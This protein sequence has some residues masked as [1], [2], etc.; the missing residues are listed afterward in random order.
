MTS[1]GRGARAARRGVWSIALLASV[2]E[3]TVLPMKL[4]IELP[5]AQAEKL[6]AEAERLGLSAEELARAALNDLLSAPDPEFQAVARRVVSKNQDLYKRLPDAY[7]T[8]GEVVALHRAILET[9]GGASGIRDLGAWSRRSL[10]PE[11]VS[12]ARTCTVRCMRR[13]RPWAFPW[14]STTRSSTAISAWPTP[15]WTRT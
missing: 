10:N 7:L 9:S 4:A 6:R 5:P 15:R 2:G 3:V 14:P 12:V 11:P 13:R 1:A 8:L